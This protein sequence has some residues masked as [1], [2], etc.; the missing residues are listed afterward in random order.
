MR[1][2]TLFIVSFVFI[3]L[4]LS[5]IQDGEALTK[6]KCFEAKVFPSGKCGR[7]GNYNCKKEYKNS[8]VKPTNC[9]CF[10]NFDETRLCNCTFC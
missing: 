9:K 6:K 4:L 10:S 5:N 2:A 8:R 1:R 7:D 3:S